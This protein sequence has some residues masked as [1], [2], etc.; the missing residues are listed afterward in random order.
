MKVLS[1]ACTVSTAEQ[2]WAIHDHIQSKKRN[3]LTQERVDKLV[4]T[5]I[6]LN[7]RMKEQQLSAED[8]LASRRAR[9][10]VSD[11]N[12]D[13]SSESDTSC[14]SHDGGDCDREESD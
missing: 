8:I 13:S 14:H 11:D 5:S 4:F 3:G 6:N 12:Q 2:N 10:S 7:I 1:Q 9:W